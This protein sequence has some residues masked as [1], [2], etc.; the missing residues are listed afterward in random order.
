MTNVGARTAYTFDKGRLHLESYGAEI[1]A[2]MRVDGLWKYEAA[3]LA[4]H[5]GQSTK[6]TRAKCRTKQLPYMRGWSIS[7]LACQ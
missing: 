6:T 1:N 3:H 4:Y 2:R 5:M 7:M